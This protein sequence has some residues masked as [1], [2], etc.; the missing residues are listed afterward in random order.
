V[1]E[2][3]EVVEENEVTSSWGQKV[4]WVGWAIPRTVVPISLK[5]GCKSE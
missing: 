3:E 5:G 1:Y 4:G 2:K